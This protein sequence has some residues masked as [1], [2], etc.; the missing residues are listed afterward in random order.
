[1]RKKSNLRVGVFR[2]LLIT[3]TICL[4]VVAGVMC[5]AVGSYS[6]AKYGTG[7]YLRERVCR[8]Y[9]W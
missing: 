6:F 9:S 5:S 1:M 3:T 7:G 2:K 8:F 4:L